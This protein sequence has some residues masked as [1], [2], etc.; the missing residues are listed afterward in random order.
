MAP[1]MCITPCT[2]T[3]AEP[4]PSASS[5]VARSAHRSDGTESKPQLGTMSAPDARAASSWRSITRATHGISPLMSTYETPPAAHAPTSASE[6]FEKGPAVDRTARVSPA[7]RA[8]DASSASQPPST[9]TGAAPTPA[10]RPGCASISAATAS[11]RAA[12]RPASAQRRPDGALRR[13]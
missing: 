9:D 4:V 1:V 5:R 10:A 3:H 12:S 2:D 8:A 11:R 6:Y 7:M 13:R